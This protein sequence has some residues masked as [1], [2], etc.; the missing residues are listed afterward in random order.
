[1]LPAMIGAF[2][3]SF[4]SHTLGLEKFEVNLNQTINM[5][6]AKNV[7]AIIVLGIAF[8]IVGRLFSV[9]LQK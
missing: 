3:A 5:T 6:N 7:I 1:M 2:V 9:L 8:G 4:T